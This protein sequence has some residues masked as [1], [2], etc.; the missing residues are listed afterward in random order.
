MDCLGSIVCTDH[1]IH[2]VY[3]VANRKGRDE[4]TIPGRSNGDGMST[5]ETLT[6]LDGMVALT[7]GTC[8]NN[9]GRR[10]RSGYGALFRLAS[11]IGDYILLKLL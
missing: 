9:R 6:L 11:Q 4:V 5:Y 8:T 2:F 1:R 10:K 3:R 7:V